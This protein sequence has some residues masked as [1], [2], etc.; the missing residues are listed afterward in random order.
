[1]TAPEELLRSVEDAMAGELFD[2]LRA[3]AEAYRIWQAVLRRCPPAPWSDEVCAD[4]DR[5]YQ[6]IKVTEEC[7][8]AL[9]LFGV[10]RLK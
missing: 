10:G 3:R 7:V 6:R 5:A 1:M 2:A 8:E 9:G 4:I